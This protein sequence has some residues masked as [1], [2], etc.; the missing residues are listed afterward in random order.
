MCMN[1]DIEKI[2]KEREARNWTQQQLADVCG[3][4]LRTI[5]R[6]EKTGVVS[7]ESASSLAAAFDLD[8]IESIIIDKPEAYK[9]VATHLLRVGRVV[10]SHALIIFASFLLFL[11]AFGLSSSNIDSRVWLLIVC[12]VSASTLLSVSLVRKYGA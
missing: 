2:K 4:S 7:R 3:V 6:I 9:S 11:G 8:A 5:Q 10:Y 12:V 1:V